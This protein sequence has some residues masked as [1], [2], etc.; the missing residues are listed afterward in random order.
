M[1]YFRKI[2]DHWFLTEPLLFA[3]LCTHK[4]IENNKL[5]I[6]MRTGKMQIEYNSEI[7]NAFSF[8][9]VQEFLKIEV[10]RIILK[11]P[12]Q[13][14]PF[15]AIRS[16]LGLSSVI[17]IAENYES[18]LD[19]PKAKNFNLPKDLAFEEYYKLV[20]EEIKQMQCS[21][22]D[23]DND[24][25]NV[26]EQNQC[27]GNRQN[28]GKGREIQDIIDNYKQL[29]SLW[30]ED[31]MS[32][33]TINDF[34]RQAQQTNSW[35]SIPG[36]MVDMIEA[37]LIVKMDYR[38]ILNSF[39]ASVLSSK[40]KL[41][42][43]RPSRRYGFKYMGSKSEFTTKLLVAIDVSGSVEDDDLHNFFSIV[44][45][46]FKYGIQQIDVIQFDTEIKEGV[47][48]L[49]KAKKSV[50]IQG[51]GGTD[52]QCVFDY[53]CDNPFYD[54]LIIFTDGYAPTPKLKRNVRSRIL[55]VLDSE[56]NYNEH[57]SWI[58]NIPKSKGM[59]IE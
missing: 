33:Q 30:E 23:E 2:N 47:L 34:I 8:E 41:T 26:G 57:K 5:K 42:R 46:F 27:N 25:N 45:R 20:A 24:C 58:S 54:G 44:N 51:R 32:E 35:G 1:K 36:K 21:N 39:R 6:P 59:W 28:N 4:L 17:T 7:L 55:W 16:A 18:S 56:T 13:R 31:N 10:I 12:Y 53:L 48:S 3:V 43:M 9:E 40:R 19:L 49:K 29:A 38:R 14:L 11:H 22:G 50:K 52:F 15:K 37:S